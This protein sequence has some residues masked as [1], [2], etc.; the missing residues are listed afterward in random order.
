MTEVLAPC[1]GRVLALEEVPDEV[2]SSAMLGPG[3][4]L[5]P[6]PEQTTVT[7]PISGTVVKIHPHAFAIQGADG[8]GILVHLGIDTVTLGGN[9]FEVLSADG[10]AVTAGDPMIRWNPGAITGEGISAVI[11]IVVLDQQAEAVRHR[12]EP[13]SSVSAGD[14]LFT[15]TAS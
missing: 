7:A 13:A 11:P 15:V 9:G 5:D 12:A 14:S 10:E 4:A 3:L 6:L 1:P 2:F 8:V